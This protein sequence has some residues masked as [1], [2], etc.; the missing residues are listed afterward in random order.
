MPIFNH[1]SILTALLL[2]A[3]AVTGCSRQEVAETSETDGPRIEKI[4]IGPVEVTL[5]ADPASVALDRDIMLTIRADAPKNTTVNFPPIADRLKGF[6][7]AGHF[8]REPIING[9]RQSIERVFRLTPTI[10]AEYRIAPMA[11]T[12]QNSDG[13]KSWGATTPITLPLQA[14]TDQSVGTDI[15]GSLTPIWVRPATSTI[16]LFIAIAFASIALIFLLTKLAKRVQRQVRLMRMS[17]RERALEE[18]HDLLAQKLIEKHKIKDFY[19]ELTMIVRRYIERQ[20]H[21]RAPEQTTEEFLQAI[22]DNPTFGPDIIQRLREFLQAADLVKFA[23][24]QPDQANIDH[25]VESAKDYVTTDA[26]RVEQ[27]DAQ[28]NGHKGD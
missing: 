6:I 1:K 21:I 27:N 16:A 15:S 3:L 24:H 2:T 11:I 28:H 20:H 4:N 14:L 13:N 10:S 7:D 23:A 9:E 17:P 18:L 26:E 12:C 22:R 8:D 19:V 5:T 25:A